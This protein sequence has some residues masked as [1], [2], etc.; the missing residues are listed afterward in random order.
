V[1]KP[2]NGNATYQKWRNQGVDVIAPTYVRT[3]MA[4]MNG[5][6]T[7]R[8]VAQAVGMAETTTGG[9]LKRLRGWGLV[10][11]DQRRAGT[12]RPL[13]FN[14]GPPWP[15]TPEYDG[16]AVLT[17]RRIIQYPRDLRKG[18]TMVW[19]GTKYR[20][21]E[22]RKGAAKTTVAIRLRDPEH[23]RGEFWVHIPDD[24]PIEAHP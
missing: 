9:H 22:W 3:L 13:V 10:E 5:A 6:A 21:K 12:I 11:W 2:T 24:T 14:A 16:D 23:P 18:D 17:E 20:V 7:V 8:E 15:W 19:K 1:S 4:V